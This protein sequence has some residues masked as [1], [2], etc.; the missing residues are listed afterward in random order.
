VGKWGLGLSNESVDK[1]VDE[2]EAI[3]NLNLQELH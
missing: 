2:K 3:N 1:A